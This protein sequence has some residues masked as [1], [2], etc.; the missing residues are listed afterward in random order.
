M[1]GPRGGALSST[2]EKPREERAYEKEVS[3][4]AQMCQSFCIQYA[5]RVHDSDGYAER[6]REICRVDSLELIL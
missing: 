4:G 5:D 2:F 1:T 6:T 3:L